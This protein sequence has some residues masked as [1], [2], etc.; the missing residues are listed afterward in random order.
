MG[1]GGL[2]Y[3]TYTFVDP[4]K[5]KNDWAR[6]DASIEVNPG[7]LGGGPNGSSPKF[8]EQPTGQLPSGLDTLL[9]FSRRSIFEC[10][11]VPVEPLSQQ[12]SDQLSGVQEYERK[13]AGV[14]MMAGYFDSLRL[15]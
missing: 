2:I 1:K 9:E 12:P 15:Y 14:T 4:E 6:S 8:I 10:A 13:R 7:A 11:G 5:A 3:E